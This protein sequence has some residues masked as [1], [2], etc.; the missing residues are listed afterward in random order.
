MKSNTKMAKKDDEEELDHDLWRHLQS[1][2]GVRLIRQEAMQ[3]V[4]SRKAEE[5]QFKQLDI[6]VLPAE[7]RFVPLQ[8]YVNEKG[9]TECTGE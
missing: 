4:E 5:M 8:T 3:V 2:S 1:K 7:Q 9:K 6:K